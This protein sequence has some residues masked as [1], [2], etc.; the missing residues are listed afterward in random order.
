MKERRF[1]V[2]IK[3]KDTRKSNIQYKSA[4]H[5]YDSSIARAVRNKKRGKPADYRP[6]VHGK[7]K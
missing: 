1:K 2:K 7:N 6:P 3:V 5:G 4:T